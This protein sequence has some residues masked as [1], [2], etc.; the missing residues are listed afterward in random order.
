[1]R[2]FCPHCGKEVNKFN[3]PLPTVDAVIHYPG[4]G[5]VL[6]KRRFDPP[7]W[8]LPGGFIELDET[9]EQAIARE[10]LEET[11]LE[12]ELT[13]LLG[14]YSDP[15]RDPRLHTMSMVYIA[16]A[17]GGQLKAGDDAADTGIFDLDKLPEQ[18]AFDHRKI[19]G[20]FRDI[21]KRMPTGLK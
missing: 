4:Q 12:V 8:A 13:G 5:V 1:M 18:I 2:M 10:I 14:V 21:Y 3:H 19:L 6:V 17:V 7:G 9:A 16:K 11:G 15:Q 20:H